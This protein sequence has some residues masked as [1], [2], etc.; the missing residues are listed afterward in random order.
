MTF[1]DLGLLAARGLLAATFLI[2]GIAKLTNRRASIQALRDFGAPRF[3]QPLT[4]LLPPVEIAVGTGLLFAASASYAARAALALLVV[5]IAG[6]SANLARGRRPPCNCFGQVHST[7]ISWRTLVRNGVLAACATWLIAGGPPQATADLWV[8]LTSLDT[9]GRRV[10]MVVAGAVGFTILHLLTREEGSDA[11]SLPADEPASDE[12]DAPAAPYRAASVAS[13]TAAPRS[14]PAAPGPV[15]TGD[16]LAIGTPAPGFVIPDLDGHRHSLDSLRASGKPIV[17]VFSS[18]HC[19]SCQ[20]LV[21]KLPGLA[22]VHERALRMVLVTRGGV[23]QTLDK[24]GNPGALLVLLQ[25]NYEVAE[26][27]NCTTSPAAVVV[28]ADGV[29]QS[30]LATGAMAIAELISLRSQP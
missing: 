28:G 15:L 12:P 9:S 3:V 4:P 7:P 19:E 11:D 6:I 23:Q 10:A 1:T 22:A 14:G 16:G 27:Y 30:R 29:I 8:L 13:P 21:P 5:F 26:A 20:L 17:L 18:P 2:A 25:Q 24:V